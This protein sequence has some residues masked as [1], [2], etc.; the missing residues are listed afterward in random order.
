MILYLIA[1][2]GLFLFFAAGGYAVYLNP[3]PPRKTLTE[4][5]YIQFGVTLCTSSSLLFW[6]ASYLLF[7]SIT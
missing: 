5:E 6:W 1:T 7:A 4:K 2:A 3:S